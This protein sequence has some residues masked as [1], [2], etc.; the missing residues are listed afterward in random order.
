[1]YKFDIL[2]VEKGQILITQNHL[3]LKYYSNFDQNL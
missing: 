3:I 1:M 2:T